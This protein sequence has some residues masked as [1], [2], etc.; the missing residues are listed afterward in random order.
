MIDLIA[1]CAIQFL[2][3]E[4]IPSMLQDLYKETY[5][6]EKFEP[7]QKTLSVEKLENINQYFPADRPT[8][9]LILNPLDRESS[10]MATL[11]IDYGITPGFILPTTSDKSY[12]N[13]PKQF[14]QIKILRDT[15]AIPIATVQ[16]TR[17]STLNAARYYWCMHGACPAGWYLADGINEDFRSAPDGL[18]ISAQHWYKKINLPIPD[19][20]INF[21]KK[22]IIPWGQIQPINTFNDISANRLSSSY[23]F[24][25]EFK[26]KWQYLRVKYQYN[27]GNLHTSY[28]GSVIL[29]VGEVSFWIWDRLH[30]VEFNIFSVINENFSWVV[31]FI[32]MLNIVFLVKS[33]FRKRKGT[34]E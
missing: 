14:K 2:S 16:N 5:S 11:L 31:F 34:A 3:K 32:G 7:F 18:Y 20:V 12:L 24:V 28:L 30:L 10:K 8:W 23:N 25:P 21:N 9:P 27:K 1:L 33:A 22:D 29:F 15:G 19:R 26:E 17:P 4:P 13:N 6:C